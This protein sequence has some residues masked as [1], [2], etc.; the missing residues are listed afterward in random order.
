MGRP[1]LSPSNVRKLGIAAMQDQKRPGQRSAT[2]WMCIYSPTHPH[3]GFQFDRSILCVLAGSILPFA[4]SCPVHTNQ[5]ADILFYSSSIRT[6]TRRM[7]CHPAPACLYA[8]NSQRQKGSSPVRFQ[9]CEVVL[10]VEVAAQFWASVQRYATPLI[11]RA[12]V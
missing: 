2:G 11:G 10:A 5:R 7:C 3:D 9:N 6:L 1:W 4:R 12:R 8:V